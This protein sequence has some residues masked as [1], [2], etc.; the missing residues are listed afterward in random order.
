MKYTVSEMSRQLGVNKRQVQRTLKN[1]INIENG[2]YIVDEKIIPLIENH[3]N[4]ATSDDNIII[5][6]FTKEE[7]DELYKRLSEYPVLKEHLKSLINE[8]DYHRNSNAKLTEIM[9][10]LTR[11]IE[12]RNYIEANEKR[13]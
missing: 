13:G 10:V 7:Y 11:S 9:N 8:L 6:E 4:T 12:Q 1:L 2:K 5:Q 3:D